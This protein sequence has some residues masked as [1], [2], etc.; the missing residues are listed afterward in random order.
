MNAP[1]PA[2][3]GGDVEAAAETAAR[4]SNDV[5]REARFPAEAF[6]AL[7]RERLLGSLVPVAL[8]GE[9]ARL[10]EIAG[11]CASLGRA[12]G[13][14][15]LIYA[16]HQIQVASV[17]AGGLGSEWHRD[18][19]A[20]LVQEQM[21]L[22][23]VTSEELVGGDVRTSRC[24]VQRDHDT[25]SLRKA[26]PS[27]SYGVHADALLITA[28]RDPEAA[29]SEQVLVVAEAGEVILTPKAAW[30]TLGMR[31]TCS[32]GFDV[33]AQGSCAAILPVPF[34]RI[35]EIGMQ[36]VSHIVWASV[37]TGI[38]SEAVD[39]A[40]SFLRARLRRSPDAPLPG[41]ARLE[42][43]TSKLLTMQARVTAALDAYERIEDGAEALPISFM[44]SMN[45]LKTSLSE[46]GLDVV[47]DAMRVC[48]ISGYRNDGPF[49]LGRQLRDLQSAPLMV[50]NDR[51]S[52][53]SSKLLL[54]QRSQRMVF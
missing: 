24:A 42:A 36:P 20:R 16:M 38:A 4:F 37:W 40:R 5:D 47:A 32:S 54:T 11:V 8:G 41:L 2:R 39:R 28:R 27:I 12:C 53:N 14:T 33:E 13:S 7:R 34:G 18:F 29:A 1:L 31:G 46:I 22:A 15:G 35:C 44:L 43:A 30:D 19:L 25:Y 45:S 23:S 52:A 6:A 3:L 9:G 17:I 26:S 50:N 21:L 48:G 10:R 49:S 51:I